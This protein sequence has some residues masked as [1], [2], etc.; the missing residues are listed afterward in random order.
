MNKSSKAKSNILP[1]EEWQT[2][3]WTCSCQAEHALHEYEIDQED[4]CRVCYQNGC[5]CPGANTFDKWHFWSGG[6][7]FDETIT[8]YRE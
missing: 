5:E 2:H 1:F 3:V 6:D 4:E 8:R 7:E